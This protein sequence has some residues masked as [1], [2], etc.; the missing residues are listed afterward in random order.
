MINFSDFVITS[1]VVLMILALPLI[2][3]LN[4]SNKRLEAKIKAKKEEAAN[5]PI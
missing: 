2:V 1:M 5:C 4:R 3:A